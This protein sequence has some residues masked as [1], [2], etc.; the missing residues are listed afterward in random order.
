[1][2]FQPIIFGIVFGLAPVLSVRRGSLG[3]PLRS[4]TVRMSGGKKHMLTRSSLVVFQIALATIILAVT[5]LVVRSYIE[6]QNHRLGVDT[7]RLL[8]G[9]V[10]QNAAEDDAAGLFDPSNIVDVRLI[11]PA[12]AW[13]QLMVDAL[14]EA[15]IPA[16]VA[17]GGDAMGEV[18]LGIYAFQRSY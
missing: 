12:E 13:E 2:F 7:D 9:D 18:V 16:H 10:F 11:L 4:D 17:I 8:F 15:Y 1:M 14:D 6:S 3:T 5:G